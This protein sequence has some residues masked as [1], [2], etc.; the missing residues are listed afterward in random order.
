MTPGGGGRRPLGYEATRWLLLVA[1]LLVLALV[2][3]VTWARRIEPAEVLAV[4]LYVPIFVAFVFFGLAGG[5]VAAAA[6]SVAYVLARWSA[7]EA[8]GFAD[9]ASLVLSRTAAFFVF[10]AVGGWAVDTLKR[11]IVK[12]DLYDDVDDATGL[13]NA[14]A[15]LQATQ[16]EEARS[17]RYEG[18]FSV[19]LLSVPSATLSSLNRR[20]QRAALRDLGAVI[21][22]AV[23]ASDRATHTVDGERDH[24]GAVLPETGSSGAR[25]FAG[26]F[27]QLV[28][29]FLAGRGVALTPDQVAIRILT[30]PGEE[31]QLAELRRMCAAAMERE[32]PEAVRSSTERRGSGGDRAVTGY[33]PDP[34]AGGPEH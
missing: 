29:G 24:F 31:A 25:V 4:V 14:R 16:V 15:L 17:L 26:R 20:R 2:V 10:G 19:V 11:S 6:A 33:R 32:Y 12:L 13:G 18:V 34:P 23:R 7:I 27:A 22:E 21:R 1:G 5:L 3:L 9:Y 28:H 30:L 8:L